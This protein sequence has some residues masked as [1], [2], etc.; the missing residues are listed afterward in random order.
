VPPKHVANSL[1]LGRIAFSLHEPIK[2]CGVCL[3]L[4]NS[5]TGRFRPE[6]VEKVEKYADVFFCFHSDE[7]DDA[8]RAC[9]HKFRKNFQKT[10][11]RIFSEDFLQTFRGSSVQLSRQR[12]PGKA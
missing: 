4:G 6:L 3:G 8:Y 11:K 1:P 2:R 7:L 12:L 10:A 9:L 5:S